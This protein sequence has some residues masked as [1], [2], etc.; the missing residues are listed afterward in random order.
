[1]SGVKRSL[2]FICVF[3][4]LTAYGRVHKRDSVSGAYILPEFIYDP[5]ENRALHILAFVRDSSSLTT[6][7]DTVILFREKWV[8]FMVPERPTKKFK[9]W[10]TARVLSTKSYYRFK[11]Y[12]GLDSVSDKCSHHFSWS[13]WV[14]IINRM[15]LPAKL[16]GN[17]NAVDTI[18]GKYSSAETWRRD[19][20]DI[21]LRVNVLADTT[22][23]RWV[24]AFSKFFRDEV[25]FDS[26]RVNFTFGSSE[27]EA[28]SSRDIWKINCE[29]SSEGR[30]HPMFRFHRRDEPFFVTT[31]AQ[32]YFIDREYIPIKE[33]EAWG[34]VDFRDYNVIPPSDIVPGNSDEILAL[35]SRVEGIDHTD[36]RMAFEVDQRLGRAA[37]RRNWGQKALRRLTNMLIGPI[38]KVHDIHESKKHKDKKKR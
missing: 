11:N 19:G 29:I 16:V 18:Y 21:F 2:I 9:G 6:Y 8:D 33:A 15:R 31:S 5:G 34:V 32:M 17:D 22:A 4:V 27:D 13:D 30:G 12:E 35:I 3:V 28:V 7:T 25:E 14:G 26:F 10:R 37:V 36:A 38:I 23:R 1:M 20:D 24:P